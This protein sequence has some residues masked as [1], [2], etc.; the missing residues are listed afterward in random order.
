MI[1]W[2]NGKNEEVVS[3]DRQMNAWFARREK[4]N[5]NVVYGVSGLPD[6]LR[7]LY[8]SY[9]FVHNQIIEYIRIYRRSI[10]LPEENHKK[11]YDG[12]P[13]LRSKDRWRKGHMTLS[14]NSLV[15]TKS[16]ILKG[17]L[18]AVAMILRSY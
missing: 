8:L 11:N 2:L 1:W 7:F 10:I 12:R 15:I 18:L 5:E 9:I 3:Q 4:K 17:R 14:L 6:R 16:C 13:S